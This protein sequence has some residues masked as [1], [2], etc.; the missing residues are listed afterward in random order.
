MAGR[1]C[2]HTGY[3]GRLG[4]FEL[5]PVDDEIREMILQRK[6][7]TDIQDAARANG[8]KLMREDGWTKVVKGTTT[9]E[10]IVRVTKVDAV[11]L[12]R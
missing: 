12:S 3:R 9:V 2:R 10:E 11:A 7:A 5:L 6:S 8:L 1:E 4:I